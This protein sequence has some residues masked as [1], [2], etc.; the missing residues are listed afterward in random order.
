MIRA[1]KKLGIKTTTSF[2]NFDVYIIC[3]S[4]HHPNDIFKPQVD[5]LFSVINKIGSEAK[6]GSLVS[7]ESTIPKGTSNKMVFQ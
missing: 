5:G 6:N 2:K 7:I 1:E 4:T 3:I